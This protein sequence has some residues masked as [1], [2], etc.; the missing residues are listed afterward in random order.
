MDW[1][2]PQSD[3]SKVVRTTPIPLPALYVE[4]EAFNYPESEPGKGLQAL[5]PC[6]SHW[7]RSGSSTQPGAIEPEGER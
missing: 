3:P 7:L 5:G 4:G 2:E 1:I 6:Q